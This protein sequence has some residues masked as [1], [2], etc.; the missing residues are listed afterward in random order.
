ML[1]LHCALRADNLADGIRHCGGGWGIA[2]RLRAIRQP[3]ATHSD[4]PRRRQGD[5]TRA[6]QSLQGKVEIILSSNRLMDQ[7]SESLEIGPKM[8]SRNPL[9]SA[10]SIPE[11]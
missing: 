5:R 6:H 7:H 10:I 1:D 3:R 8:Y 11:V 4:K 2:L 9:H